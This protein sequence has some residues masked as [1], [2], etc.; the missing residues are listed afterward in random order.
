M[1]N[2]FC[3]NLRS[4]AIRTFCRIANLRGVSIFFSLLYLKIYVIFIV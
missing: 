3:G 1:L 4:M 2:Q